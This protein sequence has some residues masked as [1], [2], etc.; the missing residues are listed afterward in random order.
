V[1]TLNVWPERLPEF[2]YEASGA[3]YKAVTNATMT[4]AESDV[5]KRIQSPIQRCQNA[6]RIIL[7]TPMWN[8]SLPYKVKHVID[9]VAQRNYLFSY[10]GKQYG[11]LLKV[12]KA[13][14]VYTRVSR[15]LEG[16][17][18]PPSFD[19]HAPY[20]DFWLRLIG[21]RDLRSVIVDN[22]WNRD[23]PEIRNMK[24]K[25]L[26][27][28][29]AELEQ[30]DPSSALLKSAVQLAP[31]GCGTATGEATRVFTVNG[32]VRPKIAIASGDKQFWRIVNASPDL[33]ADLEVDS[34]SMTVVALDGMPLTYHDPK[35]RTEKLRHVLLA[36]AGRVEVIIKGPK[37][38]RTTSLRS[39]CVN[40]GAG[41]DPNPEMVL[42]DLDTGARESAPT[43]SVQA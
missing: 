17:P 35:R 15:F 29:D 39:L 22:A 13:I 5:W 2:D 6:D 36:P 4:E 31:Y 9:L 37:P 10:D 23:R 42:A 33:Y 12:E 40:T 27:L 41:G 8:F 18:I 21:V 7:G 11:P 20:L 34:E 26:I 14:A 1:D 38:N 25:I 3:K 16:T 19:H 32:V 30:S 28:R 43:H 24:E